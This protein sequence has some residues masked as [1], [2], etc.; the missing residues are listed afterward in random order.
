[1]GQGR[2][3]GLEA[4]TPMPLELGNTGTI[5]AASDLHVT[6]YLGMWAE[7]DGS[8][9]QNSYEY[10]CKGRPTHQRSIHDLQPAGGVP[11]CRSPPGCTVSDRKIPGG[12]TGASMGGEDP[13]PLPS[14]L[15]RW[16]HPPPSRMAAPQ[17]SSSVADRAQIS[18]RVTDQFKTLSDQPDQH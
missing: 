6:M 11:T 1:M 5:P 10:D 4:A 2:L 7:P 12:L 18:D 17:S 8:R 3:L 15:P 9:R 16:P 14:A 13:C